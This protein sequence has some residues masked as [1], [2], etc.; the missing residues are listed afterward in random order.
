M[1]SQLIG[2]EQ[3][4]KQSSD[5]HRTDRRLD[6]VLQEVAGCI[7]PVWP[8]KDYVAVNP[9]F[10]LCDRSF[11]SARTYLRVFSECETL[12]PID[13]YAAQWRSGNLNA[14]DIEQALTEIDWP[15]SIPS[16]DTSNI[17]RILEQMK[18]TTVP[19]RNSPVSRSRPVCCLTEHAAACSSFAWHD[20]VTDEISKFCAAYYDEG[21]ASWG[22]AWKH[23]PL[24]SAWRE[25]MQIDRN[26][27][28]LGLKNMRS[29]AGQL[30]S[31]PQAAINDLL[32]RMNVPYPLWS[33]VLLSQVYSLPGWFAWAKYQDETNSTDDQPQAFLSLL[34]I[35]LAYDY[36]VGQSTG[37]QVD[38]NSYLRK[39]YASFQV[40]VTSEAQNGWLRYTLL[41]ASEIRY[42]KNLLRSLKDHGERR[43]RSQG[44]NDGQSGGQALSAQILFCI[45]V[46]SERIRRHIEA[47]SP[48]I[49]TLGCAGFFGLPIEYQLLGE[50]QTTAQLPV[51]LQPKY[52]ITEGLADSQGDEEAQLVHRR[53]NIRWWRKLWQS[54]K[55]SS[56][57]SF[58]F[59][60]VSG[61]LASLP[62]LSQT[63]GYSRPGFHRA[64]GLRSEQRLQ[65]NVE[66]NESGLSLEMQV[67]MA[68]RLLNNLGMTHHFSR[69]VVFCGHFS[70]THNNPLAAGLDCGACGGHSGAPNAS[71]MALLLN[72]TEVRLAL[73][74]R[75]ITIPPQTHFIAATHN[76]TTDSIEFM[77]P[78]QLPASHRKEFEE[79][80]DICRSAA[81]AVSLERLPQL[82]ATSLRQLRH[83]AFDWSEVRPEWGLAGNVAFIVGPRSLTKGVD[84]NGQVF[85]HSYDA[86]QDPS[87]TVL[88]A[89]MTAPMIVT[90]WINMQYYASTVDN[91]H[92][93]SGSKTIHNVVGKFGILSGNSGDLRT[94]LPIQSVHDG[95]AYRHQPLRLLVVIEAPRSSIDRVLLRHE[96]VANLVH[97]EWLSIVALE[98]HEQFTLGSNGQWT[99]LHE[100]RTTC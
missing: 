11:M 59:V 93:G 89:I 47:F 30:P 63:L 50:S 14:S 57:G 80:R 64:D 4:N 67:D 24:F 54:F 72:R 29:L 21:Q 62:L 77:E 34:A 39:G 45:D 70:H 48:S 37:L 9:Y 43:D 58:G 27:E 41:R 82:G 88:E 86:G 56:L 79:L 13:Y 35:R 66:V 51:L 81:A 25:Q 97:N 31:S 73:V 98:G 60:E 19:Q 28:I 49:A 100:P 96:L 75:G 12:M 85:L 16:L 44:A 55:S 68:A 87:G 95:V 32:I 22:N 78:D 74:P 33:V 17:L 90:N 2:N 10:G 69:L 61:L 40:E 3:H 15:T 6:A 71:L 99:C 53:T 83:R 18:S 42:R 20:Y 94:G 84:L 1:S 23:L 65:P 91:H 8:L 52:R 26:A 92:F 46:R 36:A 7:S 5:V 38:W 76:T